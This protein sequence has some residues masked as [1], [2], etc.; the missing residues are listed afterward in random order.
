MRY[1]IFS[2]IL[3]LSFCTAAPP[4]SPSIIPAATYDECGPAVQTFGTPDT[5]NTAVTLVTAPA[6]YGALLTNDGSG[7]NITYENCLPV[8]LDV[9]AVL[10]NPLT[11]VGQWNWSDAGSGC[12]MGF[13]L[14]QY[15]GSAPRP[16]VAACENNIFTPMY[17]IGSIDGGTAYNQV[18]VNLARLPDDYQYQTGA[19]VNVGYPSYTL[20]Y[21]PL[22]AG[23]EIPLVV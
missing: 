9:C 16:T 21:L 20:T 2:A 11:P 10:T 19:A 4:P 12:T 7:L 18:T 22:L 8:I 5:C 17:K 15:N 3:L 23:P 6:Q 13:W 1:A 14:P